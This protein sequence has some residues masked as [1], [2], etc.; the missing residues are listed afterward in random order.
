MSIYYRPAI[1]NG[2]ISKRPR[3]PFQPKVAAAPAL[4]RSSA[5]A[6]SAPEDRRTGVMILLI[7]CGLL[8]AAG[9][10]YALSRHFTSGALVRDE[11]KLKSTIDQ[12]TS[13]KRHLGVR[14]DQALSP[15]QLEQRNS[16]S[17]LAPMRF[18][19]AV[20][21]NAPA[22]VKKERN[23]KSRGQRREPALSD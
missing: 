22:G 10:V 7:A 17:G 1:Q 11:V 6:A 20:A 12:N 8:I 21:S 14:Y 18:D 9:F 4:G 5:P 16:G 15:D 13:E 2:H 3:Q 19:Q 23:D